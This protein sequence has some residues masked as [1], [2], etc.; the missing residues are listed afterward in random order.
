MLAAA[1]ALFKHAEQKLNIRYAANSLRIRYVP[2]DG[3]PLKTLTRQSEVDSMAGTML[4]DSE[5]ARNLELVGN[6]MHKKS[7]HSLMGSA[8]LP[9]NLDVPHRITSVF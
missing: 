9:V 6:L 2:V 4:I 3:K 5:T 7:K 1:C 8:Q